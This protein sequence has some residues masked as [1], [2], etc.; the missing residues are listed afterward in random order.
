MLF[1]RPASL[2]H[3]AGETFAVPL[4]SRAAKTIHGPR[5]HA[6]KPLGQGGVG[7]HKRKGPDRA[8]ERSEA[9]RNS[10]ESGTLGGAQSF[11]VTESATVSPKVCA[12]GDESTNQNTPKKS[13]LNEPDRVAA[14]MNKKPVMPV[15]A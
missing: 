5:L 8:T 9:G 4:K 2:P 3:G 6:I 13:P 12:P 7:I 1:L 10:P 15:R 11:G 14:M